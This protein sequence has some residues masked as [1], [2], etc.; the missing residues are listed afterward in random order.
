MTRSSSLA[1]SSSSATA[2]RQ[3]V[4]I[5]GATA[6]IGRTTAL[7]LAAAG[8]HVIATGRR[9]AEL[10]ALRQDGP[11]NLSTAVLDVTS[12]ASIA[13]AVAEV[14][15]LTDGHG[16]D[17]LVNNA[18]FGV[19]GPLTE[20]SDSELRRQYDT[21][22]FGLMA[23]TR[24]FVPAMRARG[25]GRIV[26]VSSMGGK[27]TIPFMGAYNST[28]YA[29]ESLSDALRYELRAFGVDVVLIEPGAIHTKFGDTAMG[30]VDQY[31][32]SAYAAAIA[33][34]DQLRQR[35][36]STAVGPEVVARAIHK[37][38]RRRRP[39]A[40]YVAPWYGRLVLGVLAITPTRIQDAAMRRLSY[41]SPGQ[42]R[43]PAAPEQLAPS[44][45]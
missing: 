13:A 25:R 31:K 34:A 23:V 4:L 26:N 5:T 24:A 14:D 16:V 40:R 17:V 29:L 38:I 21:N 2:A 30:P 39:A 8:Y 44:A 7:H 45:R 43:P 11:A 3:V 28:K 37:A 15:R 27:M 20:I 1:R 10:E 12:A 33:R 32:D 22:V 6:G 36:E 19:V 42:L 35:M 41:L 9:V 18:G